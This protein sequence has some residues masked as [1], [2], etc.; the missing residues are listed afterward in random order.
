[1]A[2]PAGTKLHLMAPLE[3]HV[4]ERYETLWEHAR[5]AGYVRIRVDGQTYSVDQPPE[6]DRRRKH[7]VEV[8]IDRVT[9]RPDARGRIAGSVE[10]ALALGRGVLAAAY[11]RDDL[12]EPALG[13][14]RPQP[15]L[16][17]RAL[18]AELRA[19]LAAPFLL[20]Q[21]A[22]LVPG[23]RR[24]GR[25]DGHEPGGPGPRSQAHAGRGRRGALAGPGQRRCSRAMLESLRRDDRRAAGRALRAAWRQASA[26]GD[27]RHRRAVVRGP[28]GSGPRLPLSIQGAL[29]GVG[30]GQPRFAR[31]PR[32]AGTPGRRSRVHGLRRQPAARRRGGGA[33]P[34]PHDG[35]A[36]PAAAGQAGGGVR[37]L[38]AQRDTSERSPASCSARSAT[39]CNSSSTW[40]W[41]I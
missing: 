37:G 19:A 33:A 10:N 38:E 30:G 31:L 28:A 8:V 9:V 41:S 4:G 21:S 12:P 3:I 36:L 39:G 20:Q 2:H 35:R 14:A 25:A 1:M 40:G 29:S 27:A 16:G 18:R 24:A 7:Q 17:L 15:A 11:P 23:L 13:H 34:R 26:A 6:I 22:G 32:Q 5:A